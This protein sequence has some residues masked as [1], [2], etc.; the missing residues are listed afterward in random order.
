[1]PGVVATR[2]PSSRTSYPET[3]LPASVDGAHAT[4]APA[5]V[6]AETVGAPGVDGGVVSGSTGPADGSSPHSSP[7]PS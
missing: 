6:T 3:P 5:A 1:M 4:V 7:S 2:T